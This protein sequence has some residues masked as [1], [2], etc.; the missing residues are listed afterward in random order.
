MN[1]MVVI[2]IAIAV[3]VVAVCA[4]TMLANNDK[5]N[6]SEAD[7]SELVVMKSMSD[8]LFNLYLGQ[9]DSSEMTLIDAGGT[10]E[11]PDNAVILVSAKNPSANISVEGK[12]IIIPTSDDTWYV[13]IAF[14]KAKWDAPVVQST[15][16]AYV[17]FAP[18]KAGETVNLGIFV[19]N[20]DD[21]NANDGTTLTTMGNLQTNLFNLYLGQKDSSDKTLIDDAG[22]YDVP[23]NAT[24]VLSAK[25][26]SANISVEGKKI[27]IPTSDDT[28]Y[29]TIAFDQANWVPVFRSHGTDTPREPWAFG[30]EDSPEYA[31]LRDAVA[32]RY[33]LLPYLYSAAAQSCAD[34]LPMIRHHLQR[35]GSTN[36]S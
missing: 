11:I 26:P 23:S 9:K 4:V 2:I 1:K 15:S 25:N 28:W 24:V 17:A 8:Y 32:L 30:G 12:K 21:S 36:R 22:T 10:F 20:Y 5:D 33:R 6:G 35:L 16:S 7:G 31:C 18:D 3:A 27:I 34:G 29:V 13:T 19:T 14:D